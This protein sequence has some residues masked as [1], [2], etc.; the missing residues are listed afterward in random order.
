MRRRVPDEPGSRPAGEPLRHSRRFSDE[1][2]EEACHV[3]QKRT[4]R[5][6]T[7][8][9]GRQILENLMGFFSILHEWDRTG[10]R[11]LDDDGASPGNGPDANR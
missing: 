6:L 8:E 5:K 9:D 4:T 11:L 10:T 7:H 3:F 1:L 2:V